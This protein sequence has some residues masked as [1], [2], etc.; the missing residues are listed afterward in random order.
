MSLT[1]Q[2][3]KPCSQIQDFSN[4]DKVLKKKK[5]P[6]KWNHMSL[7]PSTVTDVGQPGAFGFQPLQSPA[8]LI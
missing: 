5:N 1:W 2:I 7:R 8:E 6:K 3:A 4:P